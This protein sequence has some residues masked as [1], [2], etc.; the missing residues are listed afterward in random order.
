MIHTPIQLQIGNEY[1]VSLY[2][3]QYSPARR[4]GGGL[5]QVRYVCRVVDVQKGYHRHSIIW[6]MLPSDNIQT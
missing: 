5:K 4:V 3:D 1:T 6:G 2:P